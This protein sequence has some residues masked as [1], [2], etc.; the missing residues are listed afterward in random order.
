MDSQSRDNGARACCCAG[1]SLLQPDL[2]A[3]EAGDACSS[4]GIERLA[5]AGATGLASSA[6]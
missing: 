5:D 2:L 3:A 4:P 6:L 1:V